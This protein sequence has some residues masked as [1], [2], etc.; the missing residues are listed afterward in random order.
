MR[1]P[2][3]GTSTKRM[4]HKWMVDL[5]V[6]III[7]RLRLMWVGIHTFWFMLCGVVVQL[8]PRASS[9]ALPLI[10]IYGGK[11]AVSTNCTTIILFYGR[12][13]LAGCHFRVIHST[14]REGGADWNYIVVCSSRRVARRDYNYPVA[15]T[16]D[17]I[18]SPG[19]R[20]PDCISI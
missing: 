20:Y 7:R 13:T 5:P 10:A 19:I 18:N 14:G 9:Q 12:A 2:L 3:Q 15:L 4:K 11:H 8:F 16:V 1:I 17:L 6:S